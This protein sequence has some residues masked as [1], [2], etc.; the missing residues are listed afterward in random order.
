MTFPL[1][2]TSTNQIVQWLL[3][4]FTIAIFL[5]AIYLLLFLILR[6]Y[7]KKNKLAARTKGNKLEIG[8]IAH[9]Y[10]DLNSS[11][12]GYIMIDQKDSV[13]FYKAISGQQIEEGTA[14]VVIELKQDYCKVK[15]LISRVV[16]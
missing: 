16:S 10:T 15:P 5:L 8:Q 3:Q 11:D 4:L 13:F 6:H 12:T 1:F 9:A 7:E 14:V 2:P